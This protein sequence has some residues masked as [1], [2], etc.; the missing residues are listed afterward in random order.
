MS[1]YLMGHSYDYITQVKTEIFDVFKC[2]SDNTVV[3]LGSMLI[4]VVCD[5][6]AC[7]KTSG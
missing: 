2:A 1:T 5:V 7:V 4:I 6:D 3:W